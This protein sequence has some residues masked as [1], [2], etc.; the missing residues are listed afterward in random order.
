M[1]IQIFLGASD[2]CW[3]PDQTPKCYPVVLPNCLSE[4][5][6]EAG[7]LEGKFTRLHDREAKSRWEADEPE[8]G[9]EARTP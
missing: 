8:T 3:Q 2:P 6:D 5:T 1:A 7:V 4:T 9:I